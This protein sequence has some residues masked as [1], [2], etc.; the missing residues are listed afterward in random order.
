MLSLQRDKISLNPSLRAKKT[1][2]VKP[3]KKPDP[4]AKNPEVNGKKEVIKEEE[5]DKPVE[6]VCMPNTYNTNVSFPY[7]LM[8]VVL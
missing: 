4:V 8:L 3:V 5:V 2:P 6:Q 1:E 7:R